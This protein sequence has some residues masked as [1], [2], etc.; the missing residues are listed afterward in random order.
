MEHKTSKKEKTILKLF[1]YVLQSGDVAFLSVEPFLLF[2]SSNRIRH[3]LK[4]DVFE[5]HDYHFVSSIEY[6]KFRH[7]VLLMYAYKAHEHAEEQSY[8]LYPIYDA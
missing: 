1:S 3:I 7:Q 6:K 5:F 4:S 2:P 8:V